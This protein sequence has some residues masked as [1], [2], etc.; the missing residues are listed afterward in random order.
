MAGLVKN[1]ILINEEDCWSCNI[2]KPGNKE[3]KDTKGIAEILKKIL[4][5]D[6][7]GFGIIRFISST[8]YLIRIICEVFKVGV[9]VAVCDRKEFYSLLSRN[10]PIFPTLQLSYMDNFVDTSLPLIRS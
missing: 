6:E 5:H 7:E 10:K 8:K 9:R 2:T 1:L 4:I 3:I